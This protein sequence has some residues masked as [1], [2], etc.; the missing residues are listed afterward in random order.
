ML[1]T[2]A[3]FGDAAT[4]DIQTGCTRWSTRRPCGSAEYLGGRF[5][6]ALA[7]NAVLLLG[8][9]LGQVIGSAMPYL[10]PR[11]FGPFRGAALRAGVPAAPAA[12]PGA[13]GRRALYPGGAH[14]ADASR[15]PGRHRCCSSATCSWASRASRSRTPRSPCWWTR[16]GSSL[17]ED[18][19][20][21]WT[22][23]QQNTQLIGFPATLLWNRLF[24]IGVG[25]GAARRAAPPL[26]LRAPRRV[27]PAGAAG[28]PSRTRGR[29][30]PGP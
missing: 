16:S 18:L 10:D 4:R 20:R 28:A 7:V 15:V 12:Q 17:V 25:G 21:Y 23:V 22:P 29:S 24:W 27:A 14:S 13:H 9:P 8:I 6:G 3:L 19:T 11:M 30:A 5:L 2:A 1:V 26:P